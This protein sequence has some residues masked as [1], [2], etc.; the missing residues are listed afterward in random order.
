M[1]YF[2]LREDQKFWVVKFFI[3]EIFVLD[4]IYYPI[5]CD[6]FYSACKSLFVLCLVKI[7]NKYI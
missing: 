4:R 2:R 6:D 5:R 7:F 1:E 3:T